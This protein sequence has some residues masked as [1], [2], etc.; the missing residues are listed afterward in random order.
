ML[1]YYWPKA[2][3]V[4]EHY[5]QSDAHWRNQVGYFQKNGYFHKNKKHQTRLPKWA[6]DKPGLR[7]RRSGGPSLEK[8]PVLERLCKYFDRVS[9]TVV[10]KKTGEILRYKERKR[11]K[12][13]K[14][15]RERLRECGAKTLMRIETDKEIIQ[16]VF[17]VPYRD[18]RENQEGEYRDG[19]G[20]IFRATKE[21]IRE[22]L[23]KCTKVEEY[24]RKTKTGWIR[25]RR[26][27]IEWRW[28]LVPEPLVV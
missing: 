19:V 10:D 9:E 11:A 20:F 23:R 16:G 18:V 28:R 2:K 4:R 27:L 22:L 7:I 5:F 25:E 13:E 24:K 14:T 15:Y 17:E 8:R 1:R 26:S 21:M 3:W 12:N 6:M